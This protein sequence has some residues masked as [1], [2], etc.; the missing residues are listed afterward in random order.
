MEL[1]TKS[2][3]KA[4][5]WKIWT[6]TSF[7]EQQMMLRAHTY[8]M[9]QFLLWTLW[10]CWNAQFK[11]KHLIAFSTL[12]STNTL[13]SVCCHRL[14][15]FIGRYFSF[16]SWAA[17]CEWT[18]FTERISSLLQVFTC[19]LAVVPMI[20]YYIPTRYFLIFISFFGL[21]KTKSHSTKHFILNFEFNR[22]SA[23]KNHFGRT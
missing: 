5:M 19:L 9:E 6:C 11:V 13:T 8:S 10:L 1:C 14:L 20:T 23:E 3:Y 2:S 7:N 16:T 17:T 15:L 21:G 12:R 22:N 18:T 4:K